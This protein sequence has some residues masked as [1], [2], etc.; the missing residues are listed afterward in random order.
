MLMEVWCVH[1]TKTLP[2]KYKRER[3]ALICCIT[4]SYIMSHN[5]P[6]PLESNPSIMY[7]IITMKS[8]AVKLKWLGI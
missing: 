2:K 7:E 1:T 6:N 5:L 8:Y 3:E 4:Q